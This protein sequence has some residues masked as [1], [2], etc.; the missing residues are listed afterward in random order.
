MI[1][2]KTRWLQQSGTQP[3]N[4]LVLEISVRSQMPVMVTY[5]TAWKSAASSRYQLACY[6]LAWGPQQP[7]NMAPGA[8]AGPLVLN[9]KN[10]LHELFLSHGGSQPQLPYTELFVNVHPPPAWI[11][12][13]PWKK[14][15]RRS[16][17]HRYFQFPILWAVRKL[18][19]KYW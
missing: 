13:T 14:W 4:K 15:A 6:F 3:H 16:A 11:A 12:I 2:R 5:N 17:D 10:S 19:C 8:S 7:L 1:V 18:Q 9:S